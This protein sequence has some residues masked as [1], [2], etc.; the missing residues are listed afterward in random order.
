VCRVTH[1]GD[2]ARAN[3]P[4]AVLGETS[5]ILAVALCF[6]LAANAALA[7]LHIW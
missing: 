6:A 7:I 2:A 1:H 3:S 4:Q 5:V